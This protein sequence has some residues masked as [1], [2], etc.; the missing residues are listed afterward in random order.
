MSEMESV[1]TRREERRATG[2]AAARVV[3][4]VSVLAMLAGLWGTI[5]FPHSASLIVAYLAFVAYLIA[6]HLSRR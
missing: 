4:I 6:D 1:E 5:F 3:R 2:K